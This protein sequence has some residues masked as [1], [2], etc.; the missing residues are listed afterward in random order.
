MTP[1]STGIAALDELGRRFEAL[2]EPRRLRPRRWVA[3]ALAGLALAATP[4][5]ASVVF[6]GPPPVTEAL[7]QVGAAVDRSDPAGTERALAR[8]G[9]RVEWVLVTDGHPTNTRQVASPPAGTEIIAVLNAKGGNEV[10]DST[11]VLQIEV[12]PRGLARSSRATARRARAAARPWTCGPG[13]RR[14]PWSCRR[15]PSPTRRA[16]RRAARGC[17]RGA[18]RPCARRA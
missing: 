4:A 11:R 12:A 6:G 9:F 18:C 15:A 2:P 16:W 8:K 13:P 5:L 1:D 10:S 3:L 17:S 14:P 7:P